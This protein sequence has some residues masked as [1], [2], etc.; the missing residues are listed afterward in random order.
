MMLE[1]KKGQGKEKSSRN[2]QI[3]LRKYEQKIAH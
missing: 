2:A 1:V 3:L